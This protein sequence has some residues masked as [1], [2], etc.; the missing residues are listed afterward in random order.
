MV[1]Y[2]FLIRAALEGCFQ[3]LFF[4]FVRPSS[5]SCDVLGNFVSVHYHDILTINRGTNFQ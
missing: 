5:R 2:E 4:M 1:R 3:S